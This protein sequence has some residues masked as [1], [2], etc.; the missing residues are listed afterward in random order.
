LSQ[1]T[2]FGA[3][4]NM[5]SGLVLGVSH[6]PPQQGDAQGSPIFGVPF[7]LCVHPLSQNYQIWCSNTYRMGACF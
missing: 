5:G 3:V 7:H 6:T 1:T 4:T 2:K